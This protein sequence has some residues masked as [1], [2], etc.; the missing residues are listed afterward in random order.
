VWALLDRGLSSQEIAS[1]V[2]QRYDADPVLVER[3]TSGLPR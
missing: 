1:H 2:V 3:T